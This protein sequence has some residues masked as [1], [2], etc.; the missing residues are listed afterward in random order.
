MFVYVYIICNRARDQR[1]VH[2]SYWIIINWRAES[3]R[4]VIYWKIVVALFINWLFLLKCANAVCIYWKSNYWYS[5]VGN[6]KLLTR[7][8]CCIFNSFDFDYCNICKSNAINLEANEEIIL[9]TVGSTTSIRNF[10]SQNTENYIIFSIFYCFRIHSSSPSNLSSSAKLLFDHWIILF[11]KQLTII[12][13][14]QLWLLCGDV[15]FWNNSPF[16]SQN[17]WSN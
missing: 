3:Y 12:K 14:D 9:I 17:E 1:D 2:S 15:G 4:D 16:F 7:M 13:F 5:S 11:K 10:T 8:T 6:L